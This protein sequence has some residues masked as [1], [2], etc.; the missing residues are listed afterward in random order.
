MILS[1]Y[2]HVLKTYTVRTV[3]LM[4]TFVLPQFEGPQTIARIVLGSVAPCLRFS[5]L[6]PHCP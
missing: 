5:T 1:I 3:Q 6:P 4:R 2:V